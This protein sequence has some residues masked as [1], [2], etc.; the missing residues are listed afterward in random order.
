VQLTV[1]LWSVNQLSTEAAKSPLL[2]FINKKI[3][4]E[5]IGVESCYQAETSESRLRRLSVV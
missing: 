5:D 2:R 3:S 1:H 4:G